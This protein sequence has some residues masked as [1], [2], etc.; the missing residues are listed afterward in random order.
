MRRWSFNIVAGL[1]LVMAIGVAILWARSY[2]TADG[3]SALHF[4]CGEDYDTEYLWVVLST[5]GG[6]LIKLQSDPDAKDIKGL[7]QARIWH[8]S[9]PAHFYPFFGILYH[10]PRLNNLTVMKRLG[11]DLANSHAGTPPEIIRGAIAPHW[12]CCLGALILPGIWVARYRSRR[13][14]RLLEAIAMGLCPICGYDLRASTDRCPECGNSI[15]ERGV[16]GTT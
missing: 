13:R 16:E 2:H 11:F 9:H 1:S 3:F 7:R 12:F 10:D 8:E 6:V 5:K 4:T 15:P 14:R